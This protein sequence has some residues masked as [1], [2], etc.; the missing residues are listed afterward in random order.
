MW[1]LC[2]SEQIIAMQCVCITVFLFFEI[3]RKRFFDDKR[4]SAITIAHILGI[5]KTA[6]PKY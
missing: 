5:F 4:L 6:N 1:S 3:V 2:W